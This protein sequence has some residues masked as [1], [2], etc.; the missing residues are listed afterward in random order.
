MT[1][2]WAQKELQP[3]SSS[4]KSW[5]I[6]GCRPSL[7][8]YGDISKCQRFLTRGTPW[9]WMRWVHE[10][11]SLLW[12][13]SGEYEGHPA[14]PAIGE[15]AA[16]TG[17]WALVIRQTGSTTH[18]TGERSWALGARSNQLRMHVDLGFVFRNAKINW[19]GNTSDLHHRQTYS[20][21][22]HIFIFLTEIPK[23]PWPP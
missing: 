19:N 5:N 1:H 16:L 15:F 22:S 20:A 2:T 4:A 7:M 9:E 3:S 13:A 18:D 23:M 6:W 11:I 10:G 21:K 8:S 17:P 14:A 12:N